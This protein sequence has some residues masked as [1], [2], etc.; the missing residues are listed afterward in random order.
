MPA[1]IEVAAEAAPAVVPRRSKAISAL[2]VVFMNLPRRLTRPRMLESP[3]LEIA[4]RSNRFH[5]K[6]KAVPTLHPR[7]NQGKQGRRDPLGGR[8]WDLERTVGRR[9][10]D[11]RPWPAISPSVPLLKE[12]EGLTEPVLPVGCAVRTFKVVMVCNCTPYGQPGPESSS[13]SFRRR[14]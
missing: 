10:V 9:P 5:D 2:R 1:E 3:E 11:E 13:F 12:R 14:R 6:A 4:A 7:E 8:S